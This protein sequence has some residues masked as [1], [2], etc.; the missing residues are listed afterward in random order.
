MNSTTKRW[1]KKDLHTVIL[2]VKLSLCRH[3]TACCQREN[4]LWKSF[5]GFY[6]SVF[7]MWYIGFCHARSIE[8]LGTVPVLVNRF[9][10]AAWNQSKNS[11]VIMEFGTVCHN[12]VLTATWWMI[13][14]HSLALL[15]VVPVYRLGQWSGEKWCFCWA[16]PAKLTTRWTR[17]PRL[18]NL[19]FIYDNHG[20]LLR[21]VF[22][23][24]GFRFLGFSS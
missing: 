12:S 17:G 13:H 19:E 23:A 14:S 20:D 18:E 15:R 5:S 10:S 11:R 2:W 3:L 8:V 21:S 24:S 22:D 6:F 4:W 9:A 7:G 1:R 16:H